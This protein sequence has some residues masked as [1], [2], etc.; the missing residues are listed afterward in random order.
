M[1]HPVENQ[2]NNVFYWF[3]LALCG[4]GSLEPEHITG[5]LLEVSGAGV[6][7]VMNGEITEVKC[8]V[9]DDLAKGS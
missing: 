9:A 1:A 8:K 3:Q 7:V 5:D 2:I 4:S 6:P